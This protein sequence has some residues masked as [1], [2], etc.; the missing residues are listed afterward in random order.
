MQWSRLTCCQTK[1]A[2]AARDGDNKLPFT[3]ATF[4]RK[5]SMTR[6]GPIVFNNLERAPTIYNL[7]AHLLSGRACHSAQSRRRS[8]RAS[9]T[10]AAAA[11][12]L[13]AS[14]ISIATIA[15]LPPVLWAKRCSSLAEVGSRQDAKTCHPSARY[16][17]LV[18]SSPRPRLVPVMRGTALAG[19]D[20][21]E[22][23][24]KS[25]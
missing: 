15:G 23:R 16:C 1:R 22:N 6:S 8:I 10:C 20:V 19:D 5:A 7:L 9:P 25:S 17:P 13:F 24:S 12:T 4:S 2:H 21:G 3:R 11:L 14:V 18:N